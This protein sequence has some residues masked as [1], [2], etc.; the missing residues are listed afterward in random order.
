MIHE[1]ELVVSALVDSLE[2]VTVGVNPKQGNQTFASLMSGLSGGGPISYT[3]EGTGTVSTV[4][5]VP[6]T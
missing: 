2:N 1:D 3:A 5:N 6:A 4:L